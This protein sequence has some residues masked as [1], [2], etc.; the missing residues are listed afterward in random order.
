MT[1]GLA[2]ALVLGTLL[3]RSAGLLLGG[4]LAA[5][6]RAQQVLGWAPLAMMSA[7][8]VAS[9]AE[10]I[11]GSRVFGPEIVGFAVGIV[12]I[13]LRAPFLVTFSAVVGVTVLLRA[14]G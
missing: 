11:D 9:T 4:V 6:P 5:S 3:L 12:S 1:A 2:V 8:V 10:L 13:A 14:F 7:L